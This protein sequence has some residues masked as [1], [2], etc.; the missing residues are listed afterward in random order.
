MI[1]KN[2]YIIFFYFYFQSNSSENDIYKKIDLFGEVLEKINK[3][4][5]MK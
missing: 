5:V 3:E 2:L 1:K 4:Y